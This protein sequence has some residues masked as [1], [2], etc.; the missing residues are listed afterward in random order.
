[1]ASAG[2]TSVAQKHA[3]FEEEFL[4]CS[5]CTQ[6]YNKEEC[7]AKVL[8]F[9]H[10][11]CKSCLVKHARRQAK[12]DCPKCRCEVNMPR[13]G[14]NKLNNNLMVENLKDYQDIF[15]SR[16][17]CGSCTDV[18]K[19]AGMFCYNCTCFLCKHCVDAH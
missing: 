18:E 13:G 14:V 3:E 9:L 1:M 7:R 2:A 19:Q 10:T 11:F 17:V 4:T 12:F 6:F 15:K 8:P 5:I 16:V